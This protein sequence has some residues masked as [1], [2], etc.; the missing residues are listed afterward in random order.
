MS[1]SLRGAGS[2]NGDSHRHPGGHLPH[3]GNSSSLWTLPSLSLGVER[4]TWVGGGI[5]DPELGERLWKVAE[6]IE[7]PTVAHMTNICY[8]CQCLDA[9]DVQPQTHVLY[10][11]LQGLSNRLMG[12]WPR[13]H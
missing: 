7:E 6:A 13:P 5:C 10:L 11:S 9:Q 12:S 2:D 3:P 1:I 8:P 4:Y